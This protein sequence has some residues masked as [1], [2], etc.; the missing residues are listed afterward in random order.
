VA[1]EH[2][3]FDRGEAL[4]FATEAEALDLTP[5]GMERLPLTCDGCKLAALKYVS[6]QYKSIDGERQRQLDETMREQL[7]G[8]DASVASYLEH[9][10]FQPMSRDDVAELRRRG[11]D[12]GSHTRTHRALTQ[13][14]DDEL[15]C[16]LA[17][18]REEL[19]ALGVE[20]PGLAYPFG[21]E[22][23]YDAR[24]V[25]AARAAGY[26]YA[27]TALPGVNGAATPLLELRRG[28]YRELKK[29]RKGR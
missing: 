1:K 10:V 12:V 5:L 7:E 11:C 13:L 4:L 21:L 14:G 19:V 8:A 27:L 16:E 20:R 9:E 24:V 2:D 6:R 15:G 22:G 29:L 17:G 18:S 23:H 3:F 28:T 26:E 25:D